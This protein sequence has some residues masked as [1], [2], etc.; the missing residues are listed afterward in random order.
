MVDIAVRADRDVGVRF[1]L[2]KQELVDEGLDLWALTSGQLAVPMP[3]NDRETH[4]V[5]D[6]E[7]LPDFARGHA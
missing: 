7:G 1:G 6:A 2:A 3:W 4:A 5:G